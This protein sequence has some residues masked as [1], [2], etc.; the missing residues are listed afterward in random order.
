MKAKAQL[1]YLETLSPIY[2]K[3]IK[4]NYLIKCLVGEFY[5]YFKLFIYTKDIQ[6]VKMIKYFSL[7]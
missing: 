5:F 2:T 7:G 6:D 3:V 4:I 1:I